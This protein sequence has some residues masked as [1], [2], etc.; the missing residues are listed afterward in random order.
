[1]PTRSSSL[2]AFLPVYLSVAGHLPVSLLVSLLLLIFQPQ[3]MFFLIPNCP[4]CTLV[5]ALPDTL[6]VS[7]LFLCDLFHMIPTSNFLDS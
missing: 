5:V 4:D 3:A 1:M 7:P 6:A 2:P